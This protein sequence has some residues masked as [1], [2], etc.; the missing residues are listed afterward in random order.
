MVFWSR[1]SVERSREETFV[2]AGRVQVS[3]PSR[4]RFTHAPSGPATTRSNARRRASDR[5]TR[6]HDEQDEGPPA[7]ARRRRRRARSV[8]RRVQRLRRALHDLRRRIARR[9][10]GPRPGARPAPCLDCANACVATARIL[11]RQTDPDPGIQHHQAEGLPDRVREMRRAVRAPRPSPR[12]LPA[13]CRGVPALRARTPG[14]ARRAG[15]VVGSATRA[16]SSSPRR[17]RSRTRAGHRASRGGTE[18]SARVQLRGR[19][20]PDLVGQRRAGAARPLSP[21]QKQQQ[22][23]ARGTADVEARTRGMLQA[24]R[25]DCVQRRVQPTSN[26]RW[27]SQS[28]RES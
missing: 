19:R 20:A 9:G 12:A 27:L 25:R 16:R 1:L 11:A 21:M 18:Q 26:P 15:A 23:R 2:S 17:H 4:S 22:T 6:R 5:R 7:A 3:T 14:S 24:Q 28:W 13:V 10:R 8:H